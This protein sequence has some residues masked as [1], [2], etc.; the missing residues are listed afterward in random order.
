M[1]KKPIADIATRS[2]QQRSARRVAEKSLQSGEAS[3][4]RKWMEAE[5]RDKLS[6]V[7]QLM[8]R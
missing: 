6:R 4:Y 7:R 3:H 5:I 1:V 2:E 8:P